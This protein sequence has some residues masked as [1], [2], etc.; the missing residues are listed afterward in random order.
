M[1]DDGLLFLGI[2]SLLVR[3]SIVSLYPRIVL[4]CVRIGMRLVGRLSIADTVFICVWPDM[5]LTV[6]L[7]FREVKISL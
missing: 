3:I 1:C 6:D 7:K 5:N 4:L 2:V